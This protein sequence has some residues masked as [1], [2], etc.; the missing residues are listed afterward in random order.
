MLM[1]SLDASILEPGSKSFRR[2]K[3]YG[4]V[5]D[6]L[7]I[8][9]LGASGEEYKDGN[10]WVYPASGSRLLSLFSAYG[11]GKRILGENG[12]IITSQDPFESA[13]IGWLLAKRHKAALEVQLHGDFYG[14]SYWRQ[15][16]LLNRAR[17]YLGKFILRR[18]DSVRVV[19]DRIQKSISGM[20]CGKIHKIPVFAEIGGSGDPQY[21]KNKFP[22][23]YPILL[24]AGNLIQV[25][26]HKL[27]I[28]VFADIKKELPKAKLVIAGDGPLEKDLRFKILDLRLENDVE[29]VGYQKNLADFYA[30]ADIFVH[31]SLY[32]GWGRA[33]IEAAHFGLPI[34]M[35]DVGLAGEI[36]IDNESGLVAPVN[37]AAAM[38]AAIIKLANDKNLQKKL[39][40]GAKKV[41]AEKIL[42]KQE[43]LERL[44]QGW[45][46]I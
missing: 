17:F 33:V 24:A 42:A 25:K 12:W 20:T 9:V 29:L 5:C 35:A 16:K 15:E 27:L 44:R 10:I 2:M 36:I 34:V 11:R 3:D 43:F 4:S 8:I 1:I 37:N 22:G 13:L 23:A 28:E 46:V 30:S 31:P 26:N 14:N 21:L 39:A 7:H 40:E 45:E 41:I 18:A 19:S 6:E 32:E 38:K